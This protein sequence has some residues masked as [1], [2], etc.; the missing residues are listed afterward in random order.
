MIPRAPENAPASRRR[1]RILLALFF[2]LTL[3]A[4]VFSVYTGY[5]KRD[6]MIARGGNVLVEVR[7]EADATY[8]ADL[9]LNNQVASLDDIDPGQG[10]TVRFKPSETGPVQ[11]RLYHNARL[12]K[13]IEEGVFFPETPAKVRFTIVSPSE[14]RI[15]YPESQDEVVVEDSEQ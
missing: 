9:L 15:E 3:L 13:T 7:N 12:L 4:G 1:S 5:M 10:G 8:R 11:L 2:G 6:E 14:V